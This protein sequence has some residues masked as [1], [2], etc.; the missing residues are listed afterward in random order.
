MKW[1]VFS[2]VFVVVMSLC[3][4]LSI[5]LL[6]EVIR[7]MFGVL[8]SGSIVWIVVMIFGVEVLGRLIICVFSFYV[9]KCVLVI[10]MVLE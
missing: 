7:L 9:G 6:V 4:M 10:M 8:L 1:V 3:C 2:F 5:L